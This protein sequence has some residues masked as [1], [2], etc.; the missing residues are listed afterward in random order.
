MISRHS[1]QVECWFL[2]NSP[3]V[4]Y[5][6]RI[7]ITFP[8]HEAAYREINAKYH[9]LRQMS[10]LGPISVVKHVNFR[11]S[12]QIECWFLDNNIPMDYADRINTTFP[13]HEG[14]S[15]EILAKYLIFD[16]NSDFAISA[17]N[18][19]G[20]CEGMC[21]SLQVGVYRPHATLPWDH[22]R[23]IIWANAGRY[24]VWCHREGHEGRLGGQI[25]VWWRY[26][27]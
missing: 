18:R 16:D 24:V 10:D 26:G 14:V 13:G 20:F 7:I 21:P 11:H 17:A 5:A 25:C 23:L 1:L 27:I 3:P 12:L 6:D 2:G 8:G 4:K 19:D 22:R 15:D 9:F